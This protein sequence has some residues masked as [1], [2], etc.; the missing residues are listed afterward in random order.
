M[1]T[2]F[3]PHLE[4]AISIACTSWV[5]NAGSSTRTR[6]NYVTII[7][8]Y[9]ISE[10]EGA[11]GRVDNRERELITVT[12]INMYNATPLFA[13]RATVTMKGTTFAM[14]VGVGGPLETDKRPL[15]RQVKRMKPPPSYY[16]S[17]CGVRGKLVG[18]VIFPILHRCIGLSKS[19]KFLKFVIK[20]YQTNL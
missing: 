5:N 16:G 1:T 9:C 13:M 12:S 4:A 7:A 2:K 20:F 17:Y 11:R 8:R 15:F 6:R 3:D 19:F 14:A 10:A 18:R